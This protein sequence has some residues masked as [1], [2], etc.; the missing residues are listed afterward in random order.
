[1]KKQRKTEAITLIAL[2]IT[3]VVLLI[4]A[5][6]VFNLTIGQNGIMTRAAEA[7]E[8]M[9]IAEGKEKIELALLDM[10]MQRRLEQKSCDLDYVSKNL[11]GKIENTQVVGIKGEPVVKI[12][13]TYDQYMFKIQPDLTVV[14]L[15]DINIKE[16]PDLQII[17][18]VTQTGVKQVNLTVRASVEEGEIS[19]IVKPDGSVVYQDELEYP[20]TQNG[21]YTFKAVTEKGMAEEKTITIQSIQQEGIVISQGS[22]EQEQ[23]IPCSHLYESKYDATSHWKQC[24]LCNNKI[25]VTAHKLQIEGVESCSIQYPAQI[26]YCTDGCGYRVTLAKKQHPS[27]KWVASPANREHRK[28][29]TECGA[30][31]GGERCHDANGVKLGCDT[32][33]IGTCVVCGYNYT[34]AN[35]ATIRTGTCS[36]CKKQFYTITSNYEIVD[37]MTTKYMWHIDAI[38]DGLLL[39]DKA[40]LASVMLLPNIGVELIDT[41][42]VR[43]ADGSID[44]IKV[45]RT[46]KDSSTQRVNVGLVMKYTYEGVVSDC[47]EYSG[48]NLKADNYP[49]VLQSLTIQEGSA[50]GE[51]LRKATLVAKFEETWDSI[52]EMA[53]FDSDGTVLVNWGTAAKDGNLFTRTFDIVAETTQ[54]KELTV[55]AKDRCDNIAEGK[56]TIGK[57]DTKPPILVSKTSYNEEWS[58]GKLI[59]IEAKDEG[60]G[61]VEIALSDQNDYQLGTQDGQTYYRDYQFIGDVYEDVVRIIYLKDGLGNTTSAR[62]TI[63]KMDATSPTITNIT[64]TQNQDGTLITIE[65]NDKNEKLNKEGSGISGYAISKTRE[66][67]PVNAFQSDNHFVAQGKGTY[68]I[69]AR[70]QAGNLSMTHQIEV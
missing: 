36:V 3:I 11:E 9:K 40:G 14:A 23:E 64:K 31:L 54:S 52:V 6:I 65:A 22:S 60:V 7:R 49:P 68:Y 41:S 28:T 45:L 5:G 24:I 38:M 16:E 48:Y 47:V 25:E 63:G 67:P 58:I 55:K 29:C 33:N 20:V 34:T 21:E 44:V 56:I 12:Y 27:S 51:F 66:V 1:M 42:F 17:Q 4:L 26:Q 46:N 13:L 30:N 70:D 53:L 19:E 32:G 62:I 39:E 61:K 69:W 10:N 57:I 8:Q 59:R 35:H 43:N 15:G 18:D 37:E 50:E 2:V